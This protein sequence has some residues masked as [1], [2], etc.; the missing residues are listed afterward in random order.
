M[1]LKI[2]YPKNNKKHLLK[3]REDIVKTNAEKGGAVVLL[4]VKSYIKKSE[5]QLK[6]SEHYRYFEYN[7]TTENNATV[8]KDSK[9]TN[10]SV[11]T[12]K[13]D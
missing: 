6:N 3:H 13:M 9:M 1:R 4:H 12:S 2:T 8:N 10:K 11:V 7:P 5:I